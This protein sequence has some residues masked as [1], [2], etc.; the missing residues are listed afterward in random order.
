MSQQNHVILSSRSL[1]R[2][3]DLNMCSHP[4]TANSPEREDVI[5]AS[6]PWIIVLEAAFVVARVGELS[7]GINNSPCLQ[8]EG[9][10]FTGICS[11]L[12]W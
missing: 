8:R 1:V 4:V 3:A 10:G 12:W 7:G 11:N 6:S 2:G 9:F 5:V